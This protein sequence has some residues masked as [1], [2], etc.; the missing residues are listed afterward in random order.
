MIVG[1]HQP[2]YL[3]WLPYFLKIQ[4]CDLFILLDSV[5][6]QKNGLQNRNQIK[7]IQGPR[8]LTV[9]VHQ[10]FGQKILDVAI[11]NSTAWS[12]KHWQTIKHSYGKSKFFK[13]YEQELMSI[14]K[15][16][17]M[18]LSELNTELILLMMSWMGIRTPILR[19]SRMNSIGSSS[20]LVLNLCLEVG[21]KN[22]LSGSGGKNYLDQESF[23]TSGV[24]IVYDE[25]ALP[26][27]YPQTSAPCGF[28]DNLS[29][30][31]IILCCGDEWRNYLPGKY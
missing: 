9:P 15:N 24:N 17:W 10:N 21:A 31:D 22:Y 18:S 3:P 8:W 28:I 25:S 1:I 27:S 7:T 29:A 20:D 4:K 11:D 26:N 23:R 5:G 6:F 19:S 14:Y 16:H 30:L 2:Q 12:N 13:A